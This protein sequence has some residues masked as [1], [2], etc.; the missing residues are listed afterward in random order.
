MSSINIVH[1]VGRLG[2]DPDSRTTNK[3]DIVVNLSI[4]T[5]ERWTDKDGERQER[6][7]WHRCVSWNQNLNQKVLL[8]YCHK[9]ALIGVTGK[10]STRKWQDQSGQDRYTTEIVVNQVYLLGSKGDSSN[11][12]DR[13]EPAPARQHATADDLDDDIP[14]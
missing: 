6:T 13:S 10:L 5:S 11:G 4:A 14:F 7:E 2:R 1:L 8:K 9:G 12:H 3:G